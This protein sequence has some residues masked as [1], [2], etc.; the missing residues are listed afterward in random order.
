MQI[1]DDRARKRRKL[2]RDK[3]FHAE[4]NSF[5]QTLYNAPEPGTQEEPDPDFVINPADH[6]SANER[7]YDSQ[8]DHVSESELR[9]LGC[10]TIDNLTARDLVDESQWKTEAPANPTNAI[11][12]HSRIPLSS[13]HR[14]A[15]KHQLKQV[16]YTKNTTNS[17]IPRPT[18]TR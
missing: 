10:G 18:N 14:K 7:G 15:V 16:L 17:F 2:Q 4:Y 9:D 3:V 5:L 11:A 6:V 13:A 8:R 1:P 12:T